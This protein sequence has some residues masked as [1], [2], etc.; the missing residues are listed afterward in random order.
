MFYILF[1]LQVNIIV[2]IGPA[3]TF[4]A[5]TTIEELI[6]TQVKSREEATE[7][8]SNSKE[9]RAQQMRYHR[10]SSFLYYYFF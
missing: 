9:R 4:T 6:V 10:S 1:Q 8:I 7:S 2:E 5:R 3:F